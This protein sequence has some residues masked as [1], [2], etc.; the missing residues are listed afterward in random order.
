MDAKDIETL[1]KE[2]VLLINNHIDSQKRLMEAQQKLCYALID[3]IDLEI[4]RNTS[5][6]Y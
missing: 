4:H 2:A 3:L 5:W 6:M 1:A